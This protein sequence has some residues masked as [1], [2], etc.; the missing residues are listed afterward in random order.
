MVTGIFWRVKRVG[1]Y[2]F[3]NEVEARQVQVLPGS[4]PGRHTGWMTQELA[5]VLLVKQSDEEGKG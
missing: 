1:R 4:G 2:T 5:R 3:T